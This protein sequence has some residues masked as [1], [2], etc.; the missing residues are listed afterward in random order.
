MANKWWQETEISTNKCML[1]GPNGE[2]A[3]AGFY[4]SSQVSQTNWKP[5]DQT[6]KEKHMTQAKDRCAA[7]YLCKMDMSLSTRGSANC[8]A[9]KRSHDGDQ[10]KRL[11]MACV[12]SVICWCPNCQGKIKRGMLARG[13]KG[14]E[15]RGRESGDIFISFGSLWNMPPH[16]SLDTAAGFLFSFPTASQK[17]RRGNGHLAL[18]SVCHLPSIFFFFFP[19]K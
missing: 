12:S 11:W 3:S 13:G 7:A 4:E 9:K 15:G 6:S 10:E 18:Y 8:L 19:P 16:F 14:K 17:R 2:Y 5:I 1:K